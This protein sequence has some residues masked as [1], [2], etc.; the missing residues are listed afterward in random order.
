MAAAVGNLKMINLL[1]DEGANKEITDFEVCFLR[2]FISK[3][4]KTI[5]KYLGIFIFQNKNSFIKIP[6]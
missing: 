5:Y 4:P 1:I 2:Y 6:K 3:H